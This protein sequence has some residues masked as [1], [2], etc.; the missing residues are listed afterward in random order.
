MEQVHGMDAV[1][2][3]VAHDAFRQMEKPDFDRLFG[4]PHAG[5]APAGDSPGA[6]SPPGAPA[7][8]PRVL[9]DIKG[10]LDRKEFQAGGY[11]YWCL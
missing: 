1:V 7:G 3:A 6:G 8:R 10:I 4:E 5:S 11:C 9:I 2:V